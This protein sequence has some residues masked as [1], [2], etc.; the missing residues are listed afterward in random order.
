MATALRE[1]EI[2]AGATR[3]KAR[4][5]RLAART[6]QARAEA[7][8]L[9]IRDLL[10]PNAFRLTAEPITRLRDHAILA[11]EVRWRI[12]RLDVI[13]SIEEIW[14][15]AE[16]ADLLNTLDDSLLRAELEIA[17]KLSPGAV[18]LEMHPWRRRRRGL[19]GWLL[20]EVKAAG[21]DPSR[22][23]WQ[24]VDTD[25]DR[26]RVEAGPLYDLSG[27]LHERGFRVGLTQLGAVRT[28]LSAIGKAE[29]DILQ[30]DPVLIDGLDRDR[31]QRAVVSALVGL[32]AQMDAHLA[33]GGIA[34]ES[35]VAVLIDLGVAFGQGPLLA[36]PQVAAG[37]GGGELRFPGRAA[38]LS[39]DDSPPLNGVDT[40][41]SRAAATARRDPG[42][43]AVDS[44]QP[45]LTEVLSQAARAFQTEHD[46]HAILELAADYLERVVPSDGISV[47][48]ADWDS[49][50]FRPL[51]ARS[52]KDPSYAQGVMA[53]S[54]ALGVG[55]T[56]WAFDLGAPQRVNDA[57]A[58]P[59]A[60]HVP[61]TT[62][63]D[64]SMLLIPLISGD[65]R[66][67][68]LNLVRFRREAYVANDLAAASLVGHMAAAAWRNTQLY[69]EQVQHAV[70]DSLTGLFNTRWLREA[71]RRELAMA[72]RSGVLLAILMLDLDNFKQINDSCGHA[73]GDAILRSVGRTLHRVIRAEDAAIRYGGEE[74]VLILR[75]CSLDGARRVTRAVR[76]GL[77]AIPLPPEC[78]LPTV[79]ASVG[80][81]LF[82]KHGRTVGQLLG[83]ADAAMYSAKRRGKNRASA[84]R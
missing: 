33:A 45:R 5:S 27:Q 72:E 69:A 53:H 9:A 64:E 13:P 26:E 14:E 82:P 25:D 50:R 76:K 49:G 65:Y 73:A 28:R 61:G 68:M 30:M 21:L 67:G 51:L 74:F 18:L 60:G 19:V 42:K 38:V 40:R 77:A 48:Q 29:P 44:H 55:L 4:P 24:M 34:E 8:E 79:T 57:D 36:E 2:P 22:I 81:A 71:G 15:A 43:L 12:P 1:E 56:G 54:F 31:G 23:V 39:L 78:T 7:R 62:D 16:G 32:A 59:S 20:T 35:E 6:A 58:H 10:Q 41:L 63:I 84:A 47:Y 37:E 3:V 80:I 46:P 66:L 70:T 75:D 83:A 11:Y 52:F 17:T